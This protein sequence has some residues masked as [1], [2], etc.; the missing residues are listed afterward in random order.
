M[1]ETCLATDLALEPDR[2]DID[3]PNIEDPYAGRCSSKILFEVDPAPIGCSAFFSVVCTGVFSSK[4]NSWYSQAVPGIGAFDAAAGTIRWG[5]SE[6]RHSWS[7]AVQ[8]IS[9]L[10]GARERERTAEPQATA[11]HGN[12][13]ARSTPTWCRWRNGCAGDLRKAVN[14]RFGKF[15]P[16]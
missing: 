9:K 13:G 6:S 15:P 4:G 14:A 1:R 8:L 16:S 3:T 7:K 2:L 5:G 12:R 11:R 10:K